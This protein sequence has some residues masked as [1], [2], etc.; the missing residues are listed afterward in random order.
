M[1]QSVEAVLDA[2]DRAT[3][4]LLGENGTENVINVST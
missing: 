3:A 2:A 4:Q 1:Q